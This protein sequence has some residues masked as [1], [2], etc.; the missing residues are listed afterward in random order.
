VTT[1]ETFV[2]GQAITIIGGLIGIYVKV[3]L[4]LK[5]LEVRVNM[6]EKH[7]DL[8]SK[9]LDQITEQ[10]KQLFIQLQNKADR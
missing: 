5:E 4:K 8:I 6:V 1:F 2:I 10:L 7:D 9:K 3:T